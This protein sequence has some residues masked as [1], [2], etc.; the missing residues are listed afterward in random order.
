M[1]KYHPDKNF[2]DKISEAK[3]KEIQEAYASL[4]DK[5]KKQNF[6]YDYNSFYHNQTNQN[7]NQNYRSE[8]RQPQEEPPI[9][10][11]TFSEIFH[12]MHRQ[13]LLSGNTKNLDKQKFYN[14]IKEI[15]NEK[16]ILYLLN[17]DD[18]KTNCQIINELLQCCE[19]IE[20][21][22]VKD[23]SSKLVKIAGTDNETLQKIHNYIK[24][25]EIKN[26][27]RSI[28]AVSLIVGAILLFLYLNNASSTN[29]STDQPYIENSNNRP[30]SGDLYPNTA[31]Q[32]LDTSNLNSNAHSIK[33][34]EDYSDWDAKNYET[35]SSPGCYNFTPRYKKS[36]NNRLEIKVGS[37]TDA[38]L[39]LIGLSAGKCIRYVY[40]RSRDI[41]TIR[42]I[43]EGK[44]YLKIAY[45]KDWRQ[46]IING[47]CVGKFVSNALYKKG[48]EILDFKKVYEGVRKEDGKS[49][50]SYQVPSYSLKLDVIATDSSDQFKTNVISEDE[51]NNE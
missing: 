30:Y 23:L 27:K 2:G 1:L 40:I 18:A 9:T 37:N 5:T 6:D 20:L 31:P 34:S 51:F 39:K 46:K 33:P 16:S 42:N 11:H 25:R 45:G 50:R 44:Y 32:N 49:F 26:K 48:D 24:I 41:Y 17:H 14:R 3:F 4:S 10:P 36:L 13:V 12:Q 35:G 47:K 28:I 8:Q 43:P 15:L 22:H 21:T 38:V 19:L 7:T 29:S